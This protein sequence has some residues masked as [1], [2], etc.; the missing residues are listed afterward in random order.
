MKI[1][2]GTSSCLPISLHFFALF[3]NRV[4]TS[5]IGAGK[6]LEMIRPHHSV[7]HT[8][9]SQIMNH[10]SSTPPTVASS[11]TRAPRRSGIKRISVTGAMYVKYLY[12]DQ[13]GQPTS[14]TCRRCR[15]YAPRACH[16]VP[17]KPIRFVNA[18]D[19]FG[20]LVRWVLHRLVYLRLLMYRIRSLIELVHMLLSSPRL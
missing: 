10:C 9:C 7:S 12:H 6:H 4:A 1:V 17:D 5:P 15:L 19:E 14:L 2:H 20:E 18:S 16:D 8:I 13:N 3:V 11:K